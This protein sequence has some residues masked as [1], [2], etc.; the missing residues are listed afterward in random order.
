MLKLSCPACGA[1]IEFKA[2]VS[3]FG[4]CSFC[5]SMVVRHDM[6]LENI[7][8]MA[9][10]PPDMSPLQLG[11]RGRFGNSN[12][13]LV[14]RLK[15]GWE[16]GHWTEW[17]ALFDNG[18]EGWL[19]EAQGFY[20]VSFS[21]DDPSALPDLKTITVGRSFPLAKGKLF[22]VEDIKQATCIGSEGELPMKG[23]KGRK[24]T[25]VDLAGPDNEFACLDYSEE[26][27]RL[28]VGRYAEFEDLKFT[29]LRE[30]D[31]W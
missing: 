27:V 28:F 14:G 4:V 29:M 25:S 23:P 7:G 20:M 16:Q 30:V 6:N 26:G 5:H 18:K 19:A 3:V 17:Y 21:I 9:D 22:E 24:S 10:L 15:L 13:E 31:G 1:E 11:T 8:K 2:R 12:F